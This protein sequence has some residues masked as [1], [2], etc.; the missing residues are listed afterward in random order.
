MHIHSS[1][2]SLLL[3]KVKIFSTS[4]YEIPLTRP[5]QMLMSAPYINNV[6]QKLKWQDQGY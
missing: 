4:V 2:K 5:I 6:Y 1:L 3:L